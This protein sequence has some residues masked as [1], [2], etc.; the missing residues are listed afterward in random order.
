MTPSKFLRT[1]TKCIGKMLMTIDTYTMRAANNA[2]YTTSELICVLRLIAHS[3]SGNTSSPPKVSYKDYLPFPKIEEATTDKIGPSEQTI[4]TL[5]KLAKARAI[6]LYV[7]TQLITP[8]EP[9]AN[10]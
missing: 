1:P 4:T 5:K 8:P 7:F 9:A 2:S 10:L 6:P 3:F